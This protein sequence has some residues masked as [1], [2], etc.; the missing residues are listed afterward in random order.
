MELWQLRTFSVVAKTLHFTRAS[1][2]L[3]LTQPAVSRQIKSLEEELGEKLFVRDKRKISLTAQRR[4]V[5]DYALTG[6]LS[7]LKF[8]KKCIIENPCCEKVL[9]LTALLSQG[10]NIGLVQ[11]S[12]A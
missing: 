2:E 4:V 3:E 6:T 1:K 9:S 10:L 5:L 8:V 7:Y 11:P 12:A